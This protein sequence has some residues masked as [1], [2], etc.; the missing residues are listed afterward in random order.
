MKTHKLPSIL[1]LFSVA[2]CSRQTTNIDPILKAKADAGD[3][4]AQYEVGDKLFYAEGSDMDEVRKWWMKSADNGYWKAQLSVGN[5]YINNK[6]NK[7]GR[8]YMERAAEQGSI[9]AIN[10][11]G[12][13]ERGNTGMPENKCEALKWH[14]IAEILSEHESANVTYGKREMGSAD[15]QR[16]EKLAKEWLKDRPAIAP[17]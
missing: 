6:N 12:Y 3:A 10:N 17:K 4:V 14:R 7:L 15:I 5:H 1:I 8:K 13:M 11:M 9:D 16:A 2:A